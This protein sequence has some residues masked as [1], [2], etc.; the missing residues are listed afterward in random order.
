MSPE[1]A[2]QAEQLTVR[3]E[4]RGST[5]VL[6]VTGEIDLNTAPVLGTA[7]RTALRET[8][9]LLVVD[10][11]G[12]GFMASAGL[13][14]LV[15]TR[16][17]TAAGIAFRVVAAS[18]ATARPLE[19]AGLVDLLAVFPSLAEALSTPLATTEKDPE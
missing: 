17:A 8:P 9:R 12:V 13:A 3:S 10:L 5:V 18:R 16:R 19:M 11:S 2:E 7:V 1:P 14:E 15:H 4:T 6:H